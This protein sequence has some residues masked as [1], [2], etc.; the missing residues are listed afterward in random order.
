M[1][2][3]FYKFFYYVSFFSKKLKKKKDYGFVYL[4][5][6][7]NVKDTSF[8]KYKSV[9]NWFIQFYKVLVY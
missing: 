5:Q 3:Y 4:W 8:L 2:I 9:L 1:N 7:Y 6:N